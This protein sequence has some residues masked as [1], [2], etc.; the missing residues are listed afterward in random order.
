[1]WG[2][3]HAML[4]T[5]RAEDALVAA[6]AG[7]NGVYALASYVTGG[8]SNGPLPNTGYYFGIRRYPYSTDLTKNPLTFRH[9][10]NGV[11]LPSGPPVSF[12][13]DGL[14][15]SEVHSTGEVWTSMLWECYAGLLRD[16]LGGPPRLS[17]N[18]AR[19]RMRA[20]LVAAY[21]AT[22]NAPTILEARD[23]V[24]AT[25]A[26]A[27]PND[28]VVFW[29]AFARRGAGFG[30]IAPNRNSTGNVDLTESYQPGVD[31][32]MTA[33]TLSDDVIYCDND[34]VLDNTETGHLTITLQNT[35][36][37]SYGSTTATITSTNPNVSFPGGNTVGFPAVGP[38]GTT[39]TTVNVALNGVA[40]VQQLDFQISFNDPGFVAPGPRSVSFSSRGNLDDVAG[41]TAADDAES[42]APRW[43]IT[44]NG[45]LSPLGP[46]RRQTI[47]SNDHLWH[48]PDPTAASDQYLVSPLL[49]V[50]PTGSFS[51]T[52]RHRYYFEYTAGPPIVN[53]DGGVIEISTNG[54]SSWTDIG[55]SAAPGYVGLL[56]TGGSNPLGGRSAYTQIS[57]GYPAFITTTVSLGTAFQGQNVM[58]RFRI[59]ADVAGDDPGWDIDDIAFGNVTSLP[60]NALVADRAL[61]V[62]SDGDAFI[63]RNDCAP[64]NAGVW[65]A[66]TEASNLDLDGSGGLSWSA[67]S[68]PGATSIAYDLLRSNAASTF[69]SA[70]C[71]E[72]NGT[73]LV[74]LDPSSPGTIYYYLVRSENGCGG[75]LGTDSAGTPR[76][77]ASCP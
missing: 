40:S 70:T 31:L 39:S 73:D 52:F 26:A 29:K 47:A 71:V 6:N 14:G 38:S 57:P 67:P 34:G 58:V 27:D 22:P 65:A 3:F 12:G 21:K 19:D 66:P 32:V 76:T 74:A 16:T 60:F 1:G 62:D 8:G 5:V 51:F 54:G 15:N 10:A 63:D 13:A 48:G 23:A 11:P 41:Q 36:A 44:G 7:W 50:A 59:G 2:D 30:A 18:Q 28:Y 20:Y 77:G 69:A 37:G 68:L 53:F 4:L 75:N 9:I 33:A 43:T 49:H 35:G 64:F 56:S 25:A 46:W 72:S 61:C 24:L 55:A 45:S 42:S 17:F